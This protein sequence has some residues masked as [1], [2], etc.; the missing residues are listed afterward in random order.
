MPL[1]ALLITD[2]HNM[3]ALMLALP[4][5]TTVTTLELTEAEW[6]KTPERIA[7]EYLLPMAYQSQQERARAA[8]A[9]SVCS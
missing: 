1:L 6:A 3:E 8:A 5:G 4:A 7:S 2:A 9:E